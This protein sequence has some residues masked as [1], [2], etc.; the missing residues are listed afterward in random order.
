MALTCACRGVYPW[1]GGH[2]SS[3]RLCQIKIIGHV[4]VLRAALACHPAS[5]SAGSSQ[6]SSE[7]LQNSEQRSK[8]ARKVRPSRAAA[9]LG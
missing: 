1:H 8:L 2:E 6:F 5:D 4:E 7:G 9:Y 3:V